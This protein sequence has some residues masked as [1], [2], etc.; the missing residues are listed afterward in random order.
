MRNRDEAIL[1]KKK[2]RKKSGPRVFPTL[3]HEDFKT[4]ETF[5]I[6]QRLCSVEND[7]K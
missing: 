2:I 1:A 5:P 3:E 7:K 6:G 4:I